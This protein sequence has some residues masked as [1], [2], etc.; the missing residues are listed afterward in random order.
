[1]RNVLFQIFF[2]RFSYWAPTQ[3]FKIDFLGGGKEKKMTHKHTHPLISYITSL[4]LSTSKKKNIKYK[5]K[6]R[7]KMNF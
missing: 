5:K 2:A 6:N 1:M 7:E 4:H 3:K